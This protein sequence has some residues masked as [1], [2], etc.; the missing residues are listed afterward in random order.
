M[1]AELELNP[2]RPAAERHLFFPFD[3]S[4]GFAVACK[5]PDGFIQHSQGSLGDVDGNGVK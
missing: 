2:R 5:P 4:A 3:A 1:P